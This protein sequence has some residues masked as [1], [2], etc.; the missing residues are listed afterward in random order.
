MDIATLANI[1]NPTTLSDFR[2]QVLWALIAGIILAFILGF[3]MGAN[4]VANAFGTS[5]GSKVLTL[6]QAYILAVIFESLGALLVGYNVTD[7][8]RK[9]VVNIELYNNTPKDLL[10]GQVAI[11]G[12][13]S[14]WLL[15]ATFAHMPVSTTHSIVGSTLG[16]GLVMK[17]NHGIHWR[18][19]IEIVSSWFISPIFSGFVSC[20]LYII[21]DFAVL[22]RK[23]PFRCGL[24]ALPIFYWFCFAFNVF[25]VSYQGSKIVHLPSLS[26][27]I[28]VGLSVGLATFGSLLIYFILIP[29]L[30]TNIAVIKSLIQF[31]LP[32]RNGEPDVNTLKIFSSIQAFTACFAGFAHG[33][34]DVS[35]SI[36]PLA[37]LLFIYRTM[38]T[39]QKEETP[40]YV[41][42]FGVVSICS[43]LIIL[44][45]RVIQTVGTRMSTIN[46]ASG[47][48]IEFGAAVTTLVASKI[49]LPI[50]TTHALVGSVVAVGSIRSN[51]GVKWKI[52]RDVALSW[53]VT[54]PIS[55]IFDFTKA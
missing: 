29:R 19:I 33:A 25:V 20:V 37:A 53:V 9:S 32:K 5:V 21:V 49:G 27:W 16:F 14:T 24:T 31:L 36:A 46:P 42:I 41:L 45:H 34:N 38:E 1:I 52:F 13:C 30:K 48:S 43:G 55:G 51:E 47:F 2:A 15:I 18:K 3:A 28:S 39:N 8:V 22:R 6:K 44:G 17:G 7:T 10:V 12:G 4:D 23:N 35:N 26:L 11:L 40:I 54:L 50:S